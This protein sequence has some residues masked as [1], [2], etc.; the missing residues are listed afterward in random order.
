MTMTIASMQYY[1]AGT[2]NVLLGNLAGQVNVTFDLGYAGERKFLF[3]PNYWVED[4]VENFL[5]IAALD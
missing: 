2:Y 4:E 5:L 1:K 3:Q